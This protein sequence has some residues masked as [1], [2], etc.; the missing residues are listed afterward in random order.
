MSCLHC[1]RDCYHDYCQ[2]CEPRKVPPKRVKLMCL[3]CQQ[4][5]QLIQELER[6]NRELKEKVKQEEKRN[7]KLDIFQSKLM[8][9]NDELK[10]ELSTITAALANSESRER[11]LK[12]KVAELEEPRKRI[13]IL[14]DNETVNLELQSVIAAMHQ[15]IKNFKA[16]VRE[17][18]KLDLV[19][20]AHAHHIMR[21][22]GLG[23][24]VEMS[25]EIND[26]ENSL[27]ARVEGGGDD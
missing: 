22:V 6:E 7:A 5:D 21:R 3:D 25:L 18:V 24:Y 1:G 11:K 4:K 9:E 23:D 10:N 15:I 17:R 16:V 2:D 27:L 13:L 14:S 26:R 20:T 12:E 19:A 8:D